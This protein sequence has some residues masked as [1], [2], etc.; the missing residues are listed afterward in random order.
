MI[1]HCVV[2][3][4]YYDKAFKESATLD[5]EDA[6]IRFFRDK[7]PFAAA[8]Y[9][10]EKIIG[11]DK[12]VCERVYGVRKVPIWFSEFDDHLQKYAKGGAAY[13]TTESNRKRL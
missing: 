2:S 8:V 12:E 4:S 11:Y 9:Y 13:G 6:A 7:H 1:F 3:S 10:E 5:D